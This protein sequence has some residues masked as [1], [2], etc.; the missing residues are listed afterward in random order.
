MSTAAK[1]DKMQ[2]TIEPD[3]RD[4]IDR[5]IVPILVREFLKKEIANGS[6]DMASPTIANKVAP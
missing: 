4:L 1:L 5:V 3:L 2:P 6:R